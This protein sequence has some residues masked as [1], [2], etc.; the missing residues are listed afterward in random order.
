MRD[1][2]DVRP[3]SCSGT[4]TQEGGALVHCGR[5]KSGRVRDRAAKPQSRKDPGDS[6]SRERPR[7]LYGFDTSARVGAWSTTVR[8]RLP[9]PRAIDAR[10]GESSSPTCRAAQRGRATFS[11]SRHFSATTP[12][13]SYALRVRLMI[14]S[15]APFRPQRL[16]PRGLPLAGASFAARPARRPFPSRP[17]TS[18]AGTACIRRYLEHFAP[19]AGSPIEA[20]TVQGRKGGS[21]LHGREGR[22][23]PAGKR[24]S[25]PT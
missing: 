5:W 6:A 23:S 18:S 14:E 25:V 17:R 11:A 1:G 10:N 13:R 2:P 15:P 3:S 19:G 24:P 22:R 20:R 12:T 21:A 4:P 9:S 16:R 8:R 7:A